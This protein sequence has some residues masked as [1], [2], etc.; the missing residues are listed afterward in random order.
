MREF[1]VEND[2]TIVG[3]HGGTVKA[4]EITAALAEEK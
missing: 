4:A 2:V 3:G 1:D